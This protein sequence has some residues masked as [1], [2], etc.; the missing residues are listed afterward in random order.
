MSSV[1]G[2]SPSS[3]STPASTLTTA[4]GSGGS[5]TFNIS[6]LASGIDDSQIIQELM[7]IA[8]Q[9]EVNI[10]NQITLETTRQSDL[11]AIQTQLQSLSAAVSELVDPATW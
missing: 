3:S 6:G 8:S 2:S 4:T 1:S 7:S 5:S 10:E 11:Q 9:P